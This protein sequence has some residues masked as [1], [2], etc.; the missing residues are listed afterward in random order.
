[1]KINKTRRYY[2]AII[3]SNDSVDYEEDVYA[4]SEIA[5]LNL[6]YNYHKDVISV[7]EIK[8]ITKTEF[9]GH[10]NNERIE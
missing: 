5:A 7:K 3:H 2:R 9:R 10:H 4:Y 6:I 8:E 1:M